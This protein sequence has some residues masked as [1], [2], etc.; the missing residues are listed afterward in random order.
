MLQNLP[1]IYAIREAD[2]GAILF[3]GRVMNPLD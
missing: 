2:S 1:F 3:M